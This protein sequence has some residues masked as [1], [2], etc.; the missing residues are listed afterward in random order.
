[1]ATASSW[2]AWRNTRPC[3]S[4]KICVYK[5][6]GITFTHEYNKITSRTISG[7]TGNLPS[8]LTP[9]LHSFNSRTSEYLASGDKKQVA[10]PILKQLHHLRRTCETLSP[11]DGDSASPAVSVSCLLPE[12]VSTCAVKV[13]LAG[14]C[15]A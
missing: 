10:I 7:T 11:M 13:H 14:V 12:A 15:A 3:K 9:A 4:S 2:T 1:M 5:E 8:H 6:R